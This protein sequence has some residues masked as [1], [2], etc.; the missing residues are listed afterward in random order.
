[1]QH[2]ASFEQRTSMNSKH[3]RYP[4]FKN[5]IYS[6]I[7][8]MSLSTRESRR[9]Q[10]IDALASTTSLATPDN[11][12]PGT[13]HCPPPF[14]LYLGSSTVAACANAAKVSTQ[15]R[16]ESSCCRATHPGSSGSPSCFAVSPARRFGRSHPA[17]DVQA[18]AYRGRRRL[19][20]F[21]LLHLAQVALALVH[22]V[23]VQRC[24]S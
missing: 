6:L 13:H 19:F 1:M 21:G 20:D 11:V 14:H 10:Q 8:N 5:F 24:S 16:L 12:L 23:I 15:M 17:Q 22:Q 2:I 9:Y 3:D 4:A 7:L 18:G